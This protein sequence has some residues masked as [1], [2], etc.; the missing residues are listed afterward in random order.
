VVDL[1]AV[2]AAM[3]AVDVDLLAVEVDRQLARSGRVDQ[4]QAIAEAR[5]AGWSWWYAPGRA[6]SGHGGYRHRLR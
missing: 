1:A 6:R 2:L 4:P 3:R 5:G